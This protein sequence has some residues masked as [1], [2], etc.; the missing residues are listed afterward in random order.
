MA[1]I[2]AG[3]GDRSRAFECST[4]LVSRSY[5]AAVYLKTDSRLDNLHSDRRFAALRNGIGLGTQRS[6]SREKCASDDGSVG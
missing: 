5:R 6:V 4:M 3:L 1:A 2:Y